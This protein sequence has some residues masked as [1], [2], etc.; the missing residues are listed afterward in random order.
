MFNPCTSYYRRQNTPNVMYLPRKL[1]MKSMFEDFCLRY[2]KCCSQ[3][4]YRGVLKYLNISLKSPISDKCEDCF[5]YANQIEN[6]NNKDEIEALNFKLDKHKNKA[7]QANTIYRQ[8]AN[9]D[10]NTTKVFSMDLQ[11]IFLLPIIPDS[12]TCFFT[13]HLIVFI[14]T[15]A[16]LKPKGKSYCVLWHEAVAGRKAEN[17]ADSILSIMREKRYTNNFIF[18][19]NNCTGQNKNWVLF[20]SLICTLNSKKNDS[21]ESVLNTPLL[22]ILLY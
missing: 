17:I 1:T 12:K 10:I 15:F 22:Y 18:W 5:T 6:S 16:S 9:I 3:E 19:A 11:K 4:T 8:N 21:I 13:S 20:T 14:E 7:F 2:E